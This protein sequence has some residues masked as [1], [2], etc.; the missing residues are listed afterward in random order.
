MK[1][2]I[3]LDGEKIIVF[4]SSQPITEEENGWGTSSGVFAASIGLERIEEVTIPTELE[5]VDI[6]QFYKYE[7]GSFVLNPAFPSVEERV[8]A[9]ID[10]L[11]LQLLEAVG[12]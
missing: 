3:L 6:V 5:S 11:A 4:A 10:E 8:Q 12:V 9:G 7:S 1:R 2:N